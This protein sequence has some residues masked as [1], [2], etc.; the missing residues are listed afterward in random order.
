MTVSGAGVQDV[1]GNFGSGAR[2]QTWTLELGK[3]AAPFNLFITPDLGVSPGDGLTSSNNVTLGGTLTE[4]NLTV[5]V[6]DDTIGIDFLG[7]ASVVGTSFTKPLSFDVLG[8]HILRLYAADAAQNVSS[9]VTFN[10][11]IV[12]V[13]AHRDLAGRHTLTETDTGRHARCDVLGSHQ[14]SNLYTRRSD[15]EAKWRQLDQRGGERGANQRRNLPGVESDRIQH[16]ASAATSY[17]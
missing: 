15:T 7:A 10:A 6:Y 8:A 17:R 16:P 14:H 3:P 9:N 4:A 13:S 11:F 1:A 2:S 12:S 5:R